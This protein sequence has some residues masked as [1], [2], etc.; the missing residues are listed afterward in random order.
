MK[1]EQ[2]KMVARIRITEEVMKDTY[3]GAFVAAM[4]E[5]WKNWAFIMNTE[6][7][8]GPH[9][10]MWFEWD[11]EYDPDYEVDIGF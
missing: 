6:Y 1:I 11:P 9:R 7:F 4:R 5:E 2:R 3:E 8:K 10:L